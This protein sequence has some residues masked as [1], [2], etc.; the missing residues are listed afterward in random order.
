MTV[1]A[2]GERSFTYERSA[3][4]FRGALDDD[5]VLPDAAVV[6]VLCFSGI[7]MAV[8]HDAGRRTLLAVRDGGA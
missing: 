7:A 4:P 8:L 6:D 5:D 3:S 1:D 2:T